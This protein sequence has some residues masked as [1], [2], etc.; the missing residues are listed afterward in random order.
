MASTSS[1]SP[2]VT[3][4]SDD[5]Q[6]ALQKAVGVANDAAA[7]AAAHNKTKKSKRQR[8]EERAEDRNGSGS[9][10][11]KKKSKKHGD[12]DMNATLDA[13]VS[14]D[15]PDPGPG[16]NTGE[17]TPA[18]SSSISE[19]TP[20]ADTGANA[21]KAATDVAPRKKRKKN[22]GKERARD[23]HPPSHPQSEPA[24]QD[25]SLAKGS[26]APAP[27]SGSAQPH[28]GLPVHLATSSADFLSAVVAAA[29]ATAGHGQQSQGGPT[30]DQAMQQYM[31]YPPPEFDPYTYPNPS[32][33]AHPHSHSHA[34]GQSFPGP[35]PPDVAGVLP[36]MNVTSSEEL[37][38]H[39]QEF[40]ISKVVSVLKTLGEAAAAAN[41]NLDV[42]SIFVPPPAS[43]AL[44]QPVRSEA[45]LGRPPKQKKGRNGNGAAGSGS[46]TVEAA[47]PQ[48]D[49]PD[50]AHMLANV[51][52]NASK[53]AEMVRTEGEC[54]APVRM[55]V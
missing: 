2:S 10:K 33:G 9:V 43:A 15:I 24:P 42:P 16:A 34:H 5:I 38:R 32:T 21:D 41:V 47:A 20:G 44:Q 51:W 3:S 54:R 1:A 48:P 29:S 6:R 45:I 35:F 17:S 19:P 11:K 26:P 25:A 40:D 30:F 12:E 49:N 28:N 13:N 50:H 31:T 37:L 27:A 8:D 39:L 46:G 53:L 55:Y 36:D 22:K 18:T 23:D 52:M 14:A 7:V 4:L